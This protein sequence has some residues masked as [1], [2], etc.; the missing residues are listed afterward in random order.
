MAFA[1][2][3]LLE[4]P[5]DRAIV[6]DDQD[7]SHVRHLAGMSPRRVPAQLADIPWVPLD[8]SNETLREFDPLSGPI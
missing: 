1:A 2:E 6:V 7:A 3:E 8:Q 4:R 5:P